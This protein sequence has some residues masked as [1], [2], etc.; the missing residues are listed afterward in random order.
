V[1]FLPLFGSDRRTS[2]SNFVCAQNLAMREQIIVRWLFTTITWSACVA[3]FSAAASIPM[4]NSTIMT[5]V[6]MRFI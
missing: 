1:I 4:S 3:W 6:C 5:E 2:E